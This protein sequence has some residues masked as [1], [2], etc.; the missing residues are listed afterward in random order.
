MLTR[1]ILTLT[2]LATTLTLS[3]AVQ[4]EARE[5]IRQQTNSIS[6][7]IADILFKRGIDEDKALLLSR[8]VITTNEELF[9][10]MLNN[11]INTTNI[12]KNALLEYLS[13]EA[14]YKRSV[15]LT[16]YASVIKISHSLQ[17][18]ALTRQE[19]QKL[20]D[21]VERNGRLSK[22]FS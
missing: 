4:V 15:D 17:N 8:A 22:V 10:L 12:N 19:L 20:S 6:N 7:E 21:L 5:T 16:S 11:L 9:S 14:L 18:K 13:K 1:K 2:L 3:A